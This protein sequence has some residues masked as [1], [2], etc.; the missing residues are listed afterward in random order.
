MNAYGGGAAVPAWQ[1]GDYDSLDVQVT[2]NSDG[3]IHARFEIDHENLNSQSASCPFQA[4][5][6]IAA[7]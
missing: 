1:T 5:E 4:C 3:S 2:Y 7:N 6:V